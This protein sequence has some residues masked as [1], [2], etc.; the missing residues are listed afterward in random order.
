LDSLPPGK[1]KKL[2]IPAAE[3]RV[4]FREFAAPLVKGDISLFTDGSRRIEGSDDSAVGT[5][6]YTPDLHLALKHKLPPESSVY[7]AEAWAIYQALILIES[8]RHK[9]AAIFSDS[10]SVLDAL[11]SLSFKPC[12]NYLI[13][14]IHDKF[15]SL[16]DQ[17]FSI[18][19]AWIPSHISIIG[20]EKAD[21][22]AR[23]AASNGRKPK[24]KIPYTDFYSDSTRLMKTKFQA[25]LTTDF[26]VKG[27]H[28]YSYFSQPP[29]P[30]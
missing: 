21:S 1:N 5:V 24:F 12:A 30:Y 9:V 17:G 26:L 16:S 23:Q 19:L 25:S 2:A 4:R 11:T 28:Y 27:K 20:N 13:P 3:V 18:C 15:H 8:V 22:L 29:P 6:V 14:L 10:R 7:S